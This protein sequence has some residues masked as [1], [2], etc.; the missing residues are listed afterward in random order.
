MR[1][2]LSVTIVLAL[3]GPAFGFEPTGSV[4]ADAFLS[5]LENNGY[6]NLTAGAVT[7]D[8]EAVTIGGIASEGNPGEPSL[9][10]RG[11]SL[12][13]ASVG[14]DN[15]LH[16]DE[17]R[18]DD[19]VL[20]AADRASTSS[21]A[22]AFVR[23]A[24]FQLGSAN[25]SDRLFGLVGAFD[26]L[27][28]NDIETVSADGRAVTI[29]SLDVRL[30]DRDPASR[31]AGAISMEDLTIDAALMEQAAREELAT[32][33]YERFV[34]DFAVDGSW[35]ADDGKLRIKEATLGIADVGVMTF[36]AAMDGVTDETLTTLMSGQLNMAAA[37]S[38][39]NEASVTSFQLR[40]AD[41]GV[42]DRLIRRGASQAGVERSVYIDAL[43]AVFEQGVA[44]LGSS[45]FETDVVNAARLFLSDPGTVRLAAEPD[46]PLSVAQIIG[47]S[48]MRPAALPA[49]LNVTVTAGE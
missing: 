49:L 24:R 8:G 16:A 39:L 18:Y 31:L 32:L 28:L 36:A 6:R 3:A 13:G 23:G 30:E 25:G 20:I 2:H 35:S 48:M 11:V 5:N 10:I 38:A 41:E 47:L 33:G 22:N 9:N 14:I 34:V 4:V 45:A 29:A 37:L 44:V 42:T 27:S 19:I 40:F 43:V 21:V 46:A 12:A 26:G 17:L 7:R 15:V 1:L